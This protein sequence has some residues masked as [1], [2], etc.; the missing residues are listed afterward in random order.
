MQLF[1]SE[2]ITNQFELSKEES[3]HLISVLRKSYGD[4][5]VFTDGIGGKYLCKIV[6]DNPKR[7]W[8]KVE[9]KEKIIRNAPNLT[10]AIAPTKNIDRLEWFLE[11]STEIGIT[12]IIPFISNHSERRKI[13][14]ERLEKIIVSAMKQSLK[15]YKPILEELTTFD[16]VL[17]MGVGSTKFLAH[18]DEEKPI[19]FKKL[20]K[21]Q[22]NLMIVIG[23]EGDLSK[24]EILKAKENGFKIVS[25][26]DSR[27]RTETAGIVACHSFNFMNNN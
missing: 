20:Y 5:I 27:L 26:G 22:E 24:E 17:S 10:I 12:R 19:L 3:R 6:D 16:H 25:L 18:L 9:K 13:K 2:N 7:T 11:K 4:E 15:L 21:P 14:K 1:Y 23:P 8:L